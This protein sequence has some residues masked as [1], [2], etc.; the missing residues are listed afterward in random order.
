[1]QTTLANLLLAH[2]PLAAL[3]GNRVQWDTLPQGSP[4]GTISM[5]LVSGVKDYHMLGPSGFATARVQFDCRDA[6]AAKARA[7]ANALEDRLSGFSGV[8]QGY[9]FKGCFEVGH[10]T[11]F[12]QVGAHTWFT[13]S[14][15]YMISWGLAA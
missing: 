11:S 10:R 2:A 9:Q 1:M 3:V 5:T 13:D 15:D 14:R 7:I 8:F 6:T 12:G 4:Q